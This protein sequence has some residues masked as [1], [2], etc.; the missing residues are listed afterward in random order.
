[1]NEQYIMALIDA[2]EEI[3]ELS[4]KLFSEYEKFY[5]EF[6]GKDF[7]SKYRSP[8]FYEINPEWISF[9]EEDYQRISFPTRWLWSDWR[10]EC[11][12]KWTTEKQAIEE[13]EQREHQR[14]EQ[15]E[16]N[17]YLKLKEKYE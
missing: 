16:H 15:Q 3:V 12:E 6:W 1:M 17:L 9:D 8:Y 13:R 4:D 7:I 11:I 2:R 10:K 14:R 5:K